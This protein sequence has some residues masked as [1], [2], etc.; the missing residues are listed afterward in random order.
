MGNGVISSKEILSG[1]V[2]EN[3][4]SHSPII[5]ESN[6]EHPEVSQVIVSLAVTV[7]VGSPR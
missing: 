6:V 2:N 3:D 7:T 5:T 4:S 1:V